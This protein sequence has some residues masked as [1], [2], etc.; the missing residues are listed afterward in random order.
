MS[1]VKNGDSGSMLITTNVLVIVGRPGEEF[2]SNVLQENDNLCKTRLAIIAI[3][4]TTTY[5]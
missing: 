5:F 4:V 2:M 1:G 3:A